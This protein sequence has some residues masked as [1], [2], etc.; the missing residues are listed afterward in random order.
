MNCNKVYEPFVESD[1]SCCAT[2]PGGTETECGCVD[3]WKKE[4]KAK[5]SLYQQKAAEAAKKKEEL[6]RALD[7]RNKVKGYFDN[8]QKSAEKADAIT[9][10][11]KVVL[12]IL[13]KLCKS[14]GYSV[15]AI[16]VFFCMTKELY[17]KVDEVA[18]CYNNIT[19]AIDCSNDQVLKKGGITDAW[20]DYGKKLQDVIAIGNDIFNNIVI[21]LKAATILDESICEKDYGIKAAIAGIGCIFNPSGNGNTANGGIKSGEDDSMEICCTD[22]LVCPV[23]PLKN[24]QYY[25]L[26]EKHL[27]NADTRLAAIK[28]EYDKVSQEANRLQ[29]CTDSLTKA[30]KQAQDAK[31]CK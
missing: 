23:F 8:V 18:A 16:E 1:D 26:T 13:E 21:A 24:D 9:S 11:V 20:A 14:T 10:K 27:S 30:I 19:K 2:I 3:D 22:K 17:T 15:K 4:L 29:A 12:D 28:P 6:A 25:T 31:A 5:G 7:W